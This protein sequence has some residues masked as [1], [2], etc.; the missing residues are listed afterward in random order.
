MKIKKQRDIR[1]YE[2]WN[3]QIT[4]MEIGCRQNL[5]QKNEKI[6][7]NRMLWNRNNYKKIRKIKKYIYT[8]SYK[9][10]MKIKKIK[11][12]VNIMWW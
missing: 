8:M 10:K 7:K 4:S 3:Y 1:C 9:N 5:N 6:I 2:G 11:I 12:K